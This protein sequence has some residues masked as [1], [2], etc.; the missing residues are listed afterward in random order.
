M[1]ISLFAAAALFSAAPLAAATF[2]N[3]ASFT[4][5]QGTGGFS[6]GSFDGTTFTAFDSNTN[7]VIGNVTCL[8]SSSVAL[9]SAFKGDGSAATS[10]TVILTPGKVI[11]HPGQSTSSVYVAWTA[12]GAYHYDYTAEFTQQ[13]TGSQSVGITEFYT[14]F[15]GTT[16]F[17]SRIVQDTSLPDFITGYFVDAAAGDTIGYII[18]KDGDYSHDSTGVAFTVTGQVPEPASW[19]LMIVGFA[20]VGIAARRR[21]VMA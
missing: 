8:R 9:P 6:Y 11:V 7:C 3:A 18:D 10:G 21:A 13:D 15:G 4:T 12:S 1:K 20:M 2:D 17:F 5:V 19:A 16:Q 14:P